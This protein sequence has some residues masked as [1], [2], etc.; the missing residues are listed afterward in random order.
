MKT[1]N[2]IVLIGLI[3]LANGSMHAQ[4]EDGEIEV[5]L[6]ITTDNWGYEVYWEI[7]PGGNG[8][9]DGTIAWGGNDAVGCNGGGNQDQ[10]PGGYN[11][12]DLIVEG[13]WCLT[14]G[15][16]YTLVYVDD[17][18]DGG[19]DFTV[20]VSGIILNVFEGSGDGNSWNFSVE[21]PATLDASVLEIHNY[22]Y[23]SDSSPLASGEFTNLGSETISELELQ[24][25]VN[26]GN[27]VVETFSG[28]NVSS[29][30]VEE[31][32]FTTDMLLSS[33]VNEVEVTVL[34][35]NGGVDEV[36]S[37]NS[38]S[39]TVELGP[40]IPNVIDGYLGIDASVNV[41]N[42]AAAQVSSPRDLDFHPILSR[43][44]LWVLNKGTENSGGST[45]RFENAGL[46][47]QSFEWEQDGNAW[48]FMSLPTGLAF[49]ENENFATSPG[50]YDANHDGGNPFT[51]PS[52]W[53]SEDDIYAEPSGGNGSHLDMLHASPLSQGIAH[54]VDNVYWVVDGHNKDLVRY[55]FAEDHGPG[56]SY[57]GDATLHRFS[58]FEIEK[59]P[60]DHIVSHCVLDKETGWLYVVDHG[61][62]RVMRLDINSGG[63]GGVPSFGP[64]ED[65]QEYLYVSGYTYEE[66]ISDDLIEPA[67]IDIIGNRLLVSDHATGEVI[68]YDV[69]D[70]FVELGRIET[71]TPGIMGIKVGPWGR[72]WFVNAT[73][74][75]VG[76]LEG[77]PLVV[78]NISQTVQVHAYPNP[79]TNYITINVNGAFA[80][81]SI[82]IVDSR[83]AVVEQISL[84]PSGTVTLS[85]IQYE[86]GLYL[87]NFLDQRG[88]ISQSKF[89]KL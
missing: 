76:V 70:S 64:F 75:E 39:K 2:I 34:S 59:D 3:F 77:N 85:T 63:F 46:G 22:S 41:I 23:T 57:H 69:D 25:E 33:G 81:G 47:D 12:N 8:C 26:G 37:N 52:L 35:V 28:L 1:H 14:I 4:C 78:Q 10:V 7:L 83:G 24:V 51:G 18:G 72:I 67:G 32:L 89:V 27:T 17:W 55:D 86:S 65:V 13:P 73:T 38:V 11:D 40:G 62:A 68:V 16:S 36:P 74:D 53:S 58:D 49:G 19:S 9:G 84:A 80:Q 30:E 50:V 61:N 48:H 31:F 20:L 54:E 15:E 60:N 79:T 29:N 42:T 88:A 45:V 56:N 71:G 43:F 82:Q 6:S 66:I 21:E 5:E 87:V 44:E